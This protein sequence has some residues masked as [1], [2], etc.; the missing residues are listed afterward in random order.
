MIILVTVT[1]IFLQGLFQFFKSLH[2]ELALL[3]SPQGGEYINDILQI[4]AKSGCQVESPVYFRS[5]LIIEESFFETTDIFIE[6]GNDMQIRGDPKT[7]FDV[8]VFSEGTHVVFECPVLFF[9]QFVQ[10]AH[11]VIGSGK[12]SMVFLF[13]VH[14]DCIINGRND[15]S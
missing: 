13:L 10:I 7:V 2:I 11:V 1:L 12:P 5:T 6:L 3:L 4:V 8:L 9:R 15:W 14:A